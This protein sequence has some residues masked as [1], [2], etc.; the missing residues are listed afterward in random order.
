MCCS[1]LDHRREHDV[2]NLRPRRGVELT[3]NERVG[4]STNPTFENA[5]QRRIAD[6][7]LVTKSTKDRPG[8]IH[9]TVIGVRVGSPF[10]LGDD[11][12]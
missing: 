5:K 9:S 10:D 2:T 4:E 7:E 12:P 6:V 11:Q 1:V 8:F 3:H